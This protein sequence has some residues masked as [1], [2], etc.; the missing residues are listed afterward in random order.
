MAVQA[1]IIGATGYAGLEIARLLLNHPE[2][3]LAAV[4]SVSFAGKRLSEVYP[5][6]AGCCDLELCDDKAAVERSQVVFASL[7]HGLSEELAAA[8]RRKGSLF[9]DMGAD[10]RL[11]SEEDYAQWYGG[12]YADKELHEAAVYAIPEL[13]R[14]EIKAAKLIAN[15][16]CYPTSVALGLAPLLKKGLIDQKNLVIDAKSGATG[17]GRSLSQATHF[18]DCNEAFSPYKV[19]SHRHTPEIEQTLAALGGGECLVTFVPHL[20]PVNRGIVSTMYAS[21]R[22]EIPS[23]EIHRLYRDFYEKEQFVRIMPLGEAVNLRNVTY[24]NYCDISL[25]PDPRTGRIVVCSTIDNMLKGAAGQ[26]VQNMNIALGFLEA[27]GLQMVP[28]AF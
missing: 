18:P 23:E 13:F 10:F 7:P 21:L 20:L 4:S 24:S 5:A 2:V 26:A 11:H 8:C 28:P 3:E 22:G 25:H 17:A 12:T 6:M 15:P 27:T 19:A 14:E 9:I 1:G 16:G